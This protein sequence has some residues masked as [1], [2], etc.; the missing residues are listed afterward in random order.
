MMRPLGVGDLLAPF[1]IRLRDQIVPSKQGLRMGDAVLREQPI[2]SVV[3]DLQS[4]ILQDVLCADDASCE[5][6]AHQDDSMACQRVLL[7]AQERDL[8]AGEAGGDPVQTVLKGMRSREQAGGDPSL[9]VA[10]A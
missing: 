4:T 9:T 7:G 6:P 5:V 8:M 3:V 1:R 10:G 2:Q